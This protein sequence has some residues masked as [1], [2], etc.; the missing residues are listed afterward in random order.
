MAISPL[1]WVITILTLLIT[2]LKTTHEPQSSLL[3]ALKKKAE[4]PQDQL[5]RCSDFQVLDAWSLVALM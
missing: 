3:I 2:P 5:R 4:Q 1:I